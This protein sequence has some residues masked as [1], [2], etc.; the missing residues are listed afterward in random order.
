[1]TRLLPH[2]FAALTT[3]LLAIFLTALPATAEEPFR[4][5]E[6]VVDRTSDGALD[7]QSGEVEAAIEE[8]RS[9]TDFDLF[10]VFVDSFD[11]M[12]SDEWANQTADASG[13]GNLDLLLAVATEDRES[14]WSATDAIDLNTSEL[15]TANSRAQDHFSGGDWAEGAVTFADEVRSAATGGGSAL[16]V[17]LLVGAAV[18]VAVLLVVWLRSRS[19]RRAAQPVAAAAGPATPAGPPPPP[20]DSLEAQLAT[21][22]MDDLRNRAGSALVQLDDD[23]RSSEQELGFA[24]AQFGLQAIQDFRTALSSAQK[25]LSQAFEIQAR[26]DDARP[27]SEDEQRALLTRIVVVCAQADDQLDEQAEAFAHLRNLRER[28]PEALAEIEQRAA[29]IEGTIPPAELALTQLHAT[30]PQSALTSVARAP[31]QARALLA[32]AR[33]AVGSGRE[34]LQAED[35]GGAVAYARTAEDALQ[36]AV[37]LIESVHQGGAE[38]A[39]AR[40]QLDPAIDSIRADL[41]DAESLGKDDSSV[42]ALLPRA[43]RAIE[44]AQA[45]R[46]AG[47]PIAALAQITSAEDAL[48]AALAPHRQEVE[49]DRR[50]AAKLSTGIQRTQALIRSTNDFIATNRGAVGP[51][52][53]TALADASQALQ[54]AEAVQQEKPQQAVELV[55]RAWAAASRARELAT[56]DVNRWH[57]GPPGGYGGGRGSDMDVGSLILGGLLGA[58]LGG[59]GRRSGF[60][61]GFGGSGWNSGRI[62]GGGGFGGG[63]GGGRIGGGGR[64]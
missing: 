42:R 45:G 54:R 20:P 31:E 55:N 13:L 36:Q 5:D 37:M 1:M 19:R 9:D 8:L 12:R 6:H 49:S 47:D 41:I 10:V 11:G 4:L 26:L 29:E 63:F 21:L 27:E 7:G 30:Y 17:V 58:A 32:S 50:A 25:H 2:A 18:V 46:E 56:A 61:G 15:N 23:I 51:Q 16:T 35:R 44:Q 3:A 39:D 33:E 53:R 22:S 48:D 57:Q 52:A 40:K 34:Q 38:L 64:F 60:G 62:G 43:Q 28:A 24:E 59:G 14:A